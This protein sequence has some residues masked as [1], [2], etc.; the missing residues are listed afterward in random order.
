[1]EANCIYLCPLGCT[2][3]FGGTLLN[4]RACLVDL[5]MLSSLSSIMRNTVCNE[6]KIITVVRSS[7][8]WDKDLNDKM[9]LASD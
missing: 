8:F 5:S 4:L 1:M 6:N 9:I 2:L 3:G 7:L